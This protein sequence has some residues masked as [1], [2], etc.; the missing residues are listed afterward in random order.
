MQVLKMFLA[1]LIH[2]C[3]SLCKKIGLFKRKSAK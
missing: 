2:H 1:N 3:Q